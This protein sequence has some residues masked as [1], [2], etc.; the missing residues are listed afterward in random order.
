MANQQYALY[1]PSLLLFFLQ[2]SYNRDFLFSFAYFA[3]QLW[4]CCY[5]FSSKVAQEIDA[6]TAKIDSLPR[7]C[8]TFDR[9][10][11]DVSLKYVLHKAQGKNGQPF[12]TE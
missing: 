11:Y 8:A 5:V 7:T 3:R 2:I 1:S 9:C 6:R 4:F 10:V 12:P